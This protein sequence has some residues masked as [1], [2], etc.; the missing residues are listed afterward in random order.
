MTGNSYGERI[1]VRGLVQGVGFRPTVWHLAGETGL[2]GSVWN[3]AEG[4]MIEV[5]GN[6]GQI[7]RFI[8]RLQA[9]APPL[10]VIESITRTPAAG[11]APAPGFSIVESRAGEVRTGVVADAATC[12]ACLRE[13]ND[14]GDRRYRYPFTNCT[15]CGP[16]LSIVR[17]IPYDRATTSMAV[18]PLCDFCQSEYRDPGNRRFHAQPN[19]CPDCGPRVWLEDAD[20]PMPA[21]GERDAIEEAIELLRQGAILAIKGIGG[22]HLACDAG[23]PEA[24]N[25]LRARKRRY[26]KAFALMARD[27]AMIELY[28]E[29]G[30]QERKLLKS[31][32][33]PILILPM[34]GGGR[35][36]PGIA[37][38]Q[39]TLGFMLPYTPLHHLLM[40]GLDRPIV[41]TSGNRS[42]EPQVI[43]NGVAREQL[44]GIADYWLLHDRDIVNRL[45]DSVIKVMDGA[46][47]MLRRARGYAP[48]PIAL[49]PGFE[50]APQVLAF[51][52]ELKNTFC[53]LKGGRAILSQHMGDLEDAATNRDYRHNLAL[54]RSLYDHRPEVLAVDAHPNYLSTQWGRQQAEETGAPLEVVQHH[55]AHIAGCMADNGIPLDGGEVLGVALDGLGFGDDG[56]LWGGEFLIADYRGYRRAGWMQPVPMIG[57]ARAVYEPWRNTYAHLVQAFGWAEVRDS[58]GSLELVGFLDQKPLSNLDAMVERNINCPI[59]SSCGRL[60]DAVAAALGICRERVSHEGQAA[61][62]MEAMTDPR[63]VSLCDSPYPCR[64]DEEDG[65]LVIG[66]NPLWR[67]ILD[68]LAAGATPADISARFHAGLVKVLVEAVVRLGGRHGLDTLVLSGGVFQNRILLEGVSDGARRNGLQVFSPVQTPANDGGVSLGQAVIAAARMIPSGS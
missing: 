17:S 59:A 25:G 51:G 58:Y 66:W 30:E 26:H 43:D 49:P 5:W 4:V 40:K 32:M 65:R 33:A 35:L 3:D 61:M 57:G 6:P 2:D 29:L 10:S 38:G 34:A 18:F 41:L 15:H 63:A 12:E 50:A 24:V 45:D 39:N 64:T 22:I 1:R 14:P 52:A 37:P 8:E 42:D 7:G 27:P 20:G 21:I 68:D 46:P 62:E 16:R 55:H 19:A 31:R 11:D 9:E 13:V 36:A 23:N 53:L 28:A 48:A 67:G 44:Q 56:A 60:F 54:Y 47:R